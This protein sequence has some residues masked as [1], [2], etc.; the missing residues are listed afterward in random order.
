M[1]KSVKLEID[2]I[3]A[4]LYFLNTHVEIHYVCDKCTSVGGGERLLNYLR[5]EGFVT[6]E[7]IKL[8]SLPT[9]SNKKESN[10]SEF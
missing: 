10:N 6:D 3:R 7:P 8:I 2:D 9:L 1:K 5:V 4:I